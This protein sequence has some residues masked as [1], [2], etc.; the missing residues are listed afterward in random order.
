[1]TFSQPHAGNPYLG[2]IFAYDGLLP[3]TVLTV[4]SSH[5]ASGHY[6][7]EHLPNFVFLYKHEATIL[8][9]MREGSAS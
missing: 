4:L 2:I 8:R 6:P 1:V 7:A 3:E 9:V 5:L